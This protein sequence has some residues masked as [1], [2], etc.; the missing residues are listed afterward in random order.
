MKIKLL[1]VFALA[2]FPSANAQ[3]CRNKE[4]NLNDFACGKG[5]YERDYFT[6]NPA[7]T[8]CTCCCRDEDGS[9]I[10]FHLNTCDDAFRSVPK[11]CGSCMGNDAC[12]NVVDSKIGDGSCVEEQS[13]ED[14]KNSKIKKESCHGEDACRE[15]K[16]SNVGI[17]SC[18]KISSWS[19][20][21]HACKYM[22]NTQVGNN[23]CQGRQA[24]MNMDDS[25]VGN[26]SCQG[27]ESC[28]G[29]DYSNVGTASCHGYRACLVSDNTHIG[30]RSCHGDRA[31][32]ETLES[33]VGN[34]SCQGFEGC[35]YMQR[36][37][38]G[39]NSCQGTESCYDADNTQVGD[40]SC[41]G[42]RACEETLDSTVGND[43]CLGDE[44]CYQYGSWIFSDNDNGNGGYGNRLTIGSNACNRDYT[45]RECENDSVVPDFACNGDKNDWTWVWDPDKAT[46]RPICDYCRVSSKYFDC[47]SLFSTIYLYRFTFTHH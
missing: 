31:C 42:D 35:K 41:H 32:E 45:C 9:G 22:N 33:T 47:V 15:M 4:A 21:D 23:S 7:T 34:D 3:R 13:C 14:M 12:K 38:V 26:D 44:S 29:K 17:G 28:I 30:D 46:H 11:G 24:C 2:S 36:S 8:D 16:S 18:V 40:R 25:N 5:Y 6:Q 10:A 27:T 39:N 37:N 19:D 43:S 1:A 20:F